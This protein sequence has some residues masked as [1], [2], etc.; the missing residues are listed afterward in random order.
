MWLADVAD[1]QDVDRTGPAGACWP[2]RDDRQTWH[3]SHRRLLTQRIP[4]KGDQPG[5]LIA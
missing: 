5:F 4:D 1:G 2:A 3:E